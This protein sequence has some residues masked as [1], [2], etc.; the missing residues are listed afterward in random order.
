MD[1]Y[2]CQWVKTSSSW[3]INVYRREA[4]VTRWLPRWLTFFSANFL[5]LRCFVCFKNILQ[6]TKTVRKKRRKRNKALFTSCIFGETALTSF[7]PP[8]ERWL[9]SVQALTEYN[10]YAFVRCYVKKFNAF[11]DWVKQNLWSGSRSASFI[12]FSWKS[13]ATI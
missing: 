12:P 5:T 9:C 8:I 4:F 3:L 7:W 6:T 2:P 11:S 1:I 10:L 13:I